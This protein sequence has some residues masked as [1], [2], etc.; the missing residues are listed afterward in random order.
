MEVWKDCL[1]AGR[2]GGW[3]NRLLERRMV[4]E[5]KDAGQEQDWRALIGELSRECDELRRRMG[6]AELE[7]A[8]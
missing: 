1:A 8:V 2:K 3:L 5:G 4:R 7:E 6:E